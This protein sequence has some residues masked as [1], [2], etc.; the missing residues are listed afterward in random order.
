VAEAEGLQEANAVQVLALFARARQRAIAKAYREKSPWPPEWLTDVDAAYSV[1]LRHPLGTDAHVAA[2]C[3][4]LR[5]LG[6][7]P[8][9]AQRLEEGLARFPDSW[10]LHDRLR[11]QILAEKGVATLEPAYAERLARK[12]A[13]PNLEW[14]A[15]YASLVVAEPERRAG[16]PE[17]AVAAYERAVEHYR[18][19]VQK[20]PDSQES[21]DH[22]VA[23]AFAGK[24]RLSLERGDLELAAHEILASFAYKPEAAAT[25]D[26]LNLSPV[27][28]A[29]MLHAR[30]VEAGNEGVAKRVNDG[31]D[32]LDPRLLELP[33][34]EREV[35]PAR[36]GRGGARRTEPPR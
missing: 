27:D 4:F 19:A 22:Y 29:K 8:R 6:A 18:L 9:A 25:L 35:P 13:S 23:L 15:G 1:L 5:W 31:L 11:S 7:T 17:K 21:A 14:F 20:N 32:A 10:A 30:A 24:A 28:T 3:D 34:Y 12:D 16:A 36:E 26:G 33:A 2:H